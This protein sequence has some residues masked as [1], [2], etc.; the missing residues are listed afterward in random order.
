MSELWRKYLCFPNELPG[1]FIAVVLGPRKDGTP[2]CHKTLTRE[3][4]DWNNETTKEVNRKTSGRVV[5]FA[6]EWV[7]QWAIEEGRNEYLR[8]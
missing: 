1:A 8:Y 7:I 3:C 2:Y 6:N 5:V 4:N